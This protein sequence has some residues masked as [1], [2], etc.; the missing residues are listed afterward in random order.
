MRKLTLKLAFSDLL[1]KPDTQKV[2][3]Q[4]LPRITAAI[5]EGFREGAVDVT[6]EHGD[7]TRGWWRVKTK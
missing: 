7:I 3:E 1:S 6:C 2:L 4:E 5:A